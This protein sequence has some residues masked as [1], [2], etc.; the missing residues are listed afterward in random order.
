MMTLYRV[1][2]VGWHLLA[3]FC[4]FS[5]LAMYLVRRFRESLVA[6]HPVVSLLALFAIIVIIACS[7]VLKG[8]AEAWLWTFI[9]VFAAYFW[10]LCYALVD[11][12]RKT[13]WNPVLQLGVFHPFWGSSQH[14]LARAPVHRGQK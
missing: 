14:L 6:R 3:V 4:F 9:T 7:G 5:L 2:W 12:R 8:T 10:F 11:Q 1:E 13:A